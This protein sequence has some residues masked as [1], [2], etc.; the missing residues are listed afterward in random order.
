MNSECGSSLQMQIY[1]NSVQKKNKQNELNTPNNIWFHGCVWILFFLIGQLFH[2]NCVESFLVA[3]FFAAYALI[4]LNLLIQLHRRLYFMEHFECDVFPL[5]M[6]VM[7][8]AKERQHQVVYERLCACLWAGI[9]MPRHKQLNIARCGDDE[10][11][12]VWSSTP[13]G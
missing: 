7:E 6:Y 5:C 11:G 10:N 4:C 1:H 13:L 3:S 8:C 2:Q 12:I 9:C